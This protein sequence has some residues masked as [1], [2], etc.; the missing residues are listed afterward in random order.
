MALNVL[1]L[2]PAA[3]PAAK[4]VRQQQAMTSVCRR[5]SRASVN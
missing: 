5:Y 2:L 1:M 4:Y 3:A